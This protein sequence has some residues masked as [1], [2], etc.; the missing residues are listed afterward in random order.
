MSDF[1]KEAEREKLRKKYADD[2]AK[3]ADTKRMS[4][5]L[6]KGATMTNQ[7]CDA[8]GDPLFRHNGQTFCASCQAN[9][10]QPA[11]QAD[12]SQQPAA[13]Q[14]ADADQSQPANGEA[15][16]EQ[17][18][19]SN[20]PQSTQSTPNQPATNGQP[21]QP[22]TQP[23]T[24]TSQSPA[25]PSSQSPPQPSQPSSPPAT[26][27]G[28]GLSDARQS[29]AATVTRFSQRAAETDDPRRAKELLS[30]AREAA[31]TLRALEFN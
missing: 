2:E 30:A 1:D 14:S 19:P 6:L 24:N 18:A 29:L 7:H 23:T 15:T 8:C 10:Q 31:E 21:T 4:E 28:N 11:E 17:S 5:L 20:T 26:A 22:E 16:P 25:A 27:G 3:R 13:E 9:G 12:G